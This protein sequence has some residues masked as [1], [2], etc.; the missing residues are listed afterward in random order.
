MEN[1]Q[2]A[3]QLTR[4]LT[5][6]RGDALRLP[7]FPAIY[8]QTRTNVAH[9]SNHR[10]LPRNDCADPPAGFHLKTSLELI[11]GFRYCPVRPR[12]RRIRPSRQPIRRIR[13][14]KPTPSAADANNAPVLAAIGHEKSLVGGWLS[15]VVKYPGR[16]VQ[17]TLARSG[18]Q[19]PNSMTFGEFESAEQSTAG[20]NQ[21]AQ[22]PTPSQKH[23]SI[24]GRLAN[25]QGLAP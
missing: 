2:T 21:H 13:G 7:G 12:S 18:Q 15:P 10:P 5:A 14:A 9:D 16:V 4:A 6:G 25:N 17:Q 19:L 24:P 11:A 23:S 8:R 3:K 20:V 1:S 22:T